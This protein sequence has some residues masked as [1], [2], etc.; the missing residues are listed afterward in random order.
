MVARGEGS[1]E[2]RKKGEGNREVQT[3]SYELNN[4]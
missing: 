2:R 3:P 4:S 1:G